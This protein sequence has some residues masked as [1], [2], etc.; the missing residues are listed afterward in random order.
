MSRYRSQLIS[1]IR[2][3]RLDFRFPRWKEDLYMAEE[4]LYSEG[5]CEMLIPEARYDAENIEDKGNFLWHPPDEDELF[6]EG[7]PDIELG[8][9]IEGEQQRF[10][11]RFK[12]R[13]RN[14]LLVGS[15]G[16]GKTVSGKS[17]CINIDKANQ[18]DPENPTLLIIIDP[19][20]DYPNIGK[21]LCGDVLYLSVNHNLRL[22]LNGPAD[23]PPN[24]WIIVLSISLAARLGLVMSRTCLAS[25]ISR[26]LVALNPWLKQEQLNT[27]SVNQELR[28]PSLK[29]VLEA[30]KIKAI[31]ACFSSKAS[32]GETLIQ[33]LEGLIQD[34]GEL[35][36]CSNGLDIRRDVV[37]RKRHC[38]IDVSNRPAHIVRLVVD[39]LINQE[40]VSRLY[41]NYK[42]D[43]TD[44]C[45]VIDEGDLVVEAE[46][47]A[48]F[49]DG[50]S[51]LS[52]LCRLGREM[53]MQTIMIISA[54]QKAGDHILRNICYTFVFNLTDSE[55]VY[56]A[57]LH[58][59]LDP[60]CQRM[61]GSLLPGQCI[62]RQTQSSWN[63]AMW[64]QM[65]YVAPARE[66]GPIEYEPHPYTPALSL[67]EAPEV[68]A[69]LDA[70]VEE[71]KNSQKRQAESKKS[72][73][74]QIAMKLLQLRAQNPY[75]PVARLFE[76]LEKIRFQAQ[77]KVRQILEEKGL[78]EFEE[79]RIGRSTMLLM[80]ITDE[81]F[82]A[83]DLPVPTE[84]KGRGGIAHRHFAHWI[85]QHFEKKGGQAY[86]E[87]V[88]PHINHPVD[89]AIESEKGWR[90]FEICITAFNNI[91]THIEACFKN[92]DMVESLTF[93]T[94]TKT[95]LQE[96]RKLVQT[97]ANFNSFAD[98][99][100]FEVIENYMV[101]S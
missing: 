52:K 48:I 50:M 13:P 2:R 101:R 95:K 86:L 39:I 51:P 10:G 91:P 17:I 23:V 90:C 96:L 59:Q 20:F 61:L 63:N 89:V 24:V 3:Y 87:K 80:E 4:G 74:D 98:R 82:R 8:N 42:C 99:I 18:S 78:A 19:K 65:D 49:P 1:I 60:R 67:S 33:A 15:A 71:H 76:K 14:T 7:K 85:K 6:A 5:F 77:I 38:V 79:I 22:G 45:Y 70:A 53:G 73:M 68:V 44:V 62:F 26:L 97:D 40:L 54:L 94:A 66:I 57:S 47:E 31:L 37:Q 72:N 46:H 58:L 92:Q 88:I 9:L 12:D 21:Q 83:L 41:N 56:A 81:G 35:F 27:T 34:S 16:S 93:V 64:C 29:M 28:W 69:D 25:L 32:Y 84:N 11:I 36:D 30:I 43:H 100:K 55:S 75:A